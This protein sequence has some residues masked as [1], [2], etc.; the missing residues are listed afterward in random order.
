MTEP[1]SEASLS[2][3]P[4]AATTT[5][6]RE[7]TQKRSER[8]LWEKQM[9]DR[10]GQAAVAHSVRWS[11]Y[12]KVDEQGKCKKPADQSKAAGFLALDLATGRYSNKTDRSGQKLTLMDSLA[13]GR[14]LFL[15]SCHL[16]KHKL[17]KLDRQ[18]LD[19]KMA[20]ITRK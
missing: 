20:E 18:V 19:V 11:Y 6:T 15:P 9:L 1:D 2:T 10:R 17:D 4:D 12:G 14:H 3:G 5:E 8:R 13:P 7:E 16:V